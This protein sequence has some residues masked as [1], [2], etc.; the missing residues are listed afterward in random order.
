MSNVNA[1]EILPIMPDLRYTFLMTDYAEHMSTRYDHDDAPAYDN[2]E[3]RAQA[4][5][6]RAQHTYAG[7]SHRPDYASQAQHDRDCPAMPG[8][9]HARSYRPETAEEYLPI[10]DADERPV[11]A[12]RF[13]SAARVAAERQTL[14]EMTSEDRAA[15]IKRA[16]S[17]FQAELD[18][19]APA[20]SAVL[21]EADVY[22]PGRDRT[23]DTPV[24]GQA[25]PPIESPPDG[26]RW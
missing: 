18:A 9:P 14:G 13:K 17:R 4:A 24:A 15:A 20:I 25:A 16:A 2:P 6:E 3:L 23:Q 10:T 22:N 5:A 1:R 26:W 21:D 12:D 19:S 8:Q 11:W 7:C